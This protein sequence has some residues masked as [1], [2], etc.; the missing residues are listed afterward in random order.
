L[1][2]W[3]RDDSQGR[4]C[5]AG[6]DLLVA[7]RLPGYATYRRA[8]GI[9]RPESAGSLPGGHRVLVRCKRDYGDLPARICWVATRR[10]QCA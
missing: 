9:N 3:E 8:G 10:A 5:P 7:T 2:R 4:G 1:D 6:S